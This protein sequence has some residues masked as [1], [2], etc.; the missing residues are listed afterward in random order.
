MKTHEATV[1]VEVVA[2]ILCAMAEGEHNND[3][4]PSVLLWLGQRLSEAGRVLADGGV[5]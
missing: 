2:A 1:T 3:S 5:A 4:L